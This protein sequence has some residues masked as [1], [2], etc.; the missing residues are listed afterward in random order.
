MRASRVSCQ[1]GRTG[2]PASLSSVVSRMRIL[3]LC[4]ILV[5]LAGC[6]TLGGRTVIVNLNHKGPFDGASVGQALLI[7]DKSMAREGIRR[8][9]SSSLEYGHVANYV[10]GHFICGAS[11]QDGK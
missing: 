7:V 11:T 6:D 2:P 4:F 1:F 9:A 10:G 3:G 5:L 8:A